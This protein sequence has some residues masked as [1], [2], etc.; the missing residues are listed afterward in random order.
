MFE[1]AMW[2]YCCLF[3]MCNVPCAKKSLVAVGS[4]HCCKSCC[5]QFTRMEQSTKVKEFLQSLC[6][7]FKVYMIL[8]IVYQGQS[9]Q[10]SRWWTWAPKASFWFLKL[11]DPQW[12]QLWPPICFLWFIIQFDLCLIMCVSNS[13]VCSSLWSSLISLFCSSCLS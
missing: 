8:E 2:D 9:L 6:S 13:F 4:C 1:M 11:Y 7:F 3:W 12:L 5:S 10:S